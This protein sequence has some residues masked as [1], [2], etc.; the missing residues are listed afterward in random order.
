MMTRG[1]GAADEGSSRMG[2]MPGQDFFARDAV[3]VAARMI[4]LE[5][6]FGG[7]GGLIVETEAYLPDDPASHS[8]KGPTRRN[9]S[10][11]GPPGTCYVYRSYGLHWCLNAVCLK[12]S[13][14]LIRALEPTAGAD[15]MAARRGTAEA[16]MLCAGPGRLAVAL[17][18]TGGEDGLS[19]LHPPFALRHSGTAPAIVSGPRIGITRAADMPWRFG[20]QGSRFLSRRFG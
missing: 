15:L 7:V 4:G 10:M 9:A 19:L 3:T 14:V 16:A 12:G 13:A 5:L 18:I 8:F 11:F 1:T 20:W 6:T 17:G 2:E